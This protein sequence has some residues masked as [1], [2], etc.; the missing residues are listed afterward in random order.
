MTLMIINYI[1]KSLKPQ[2]NTNYSYVYRRFIRIF[3]NKIK[4]RDSV[5]LGVKYY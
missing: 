4:S 3:P 5:F 2:I 1:I